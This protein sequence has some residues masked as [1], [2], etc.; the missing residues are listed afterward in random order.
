VADRPIDLLV[1]SLASGQ[2]N[3]DEFIDA[4]EHQVQI[5]A[6]FNEG[7]AVKGSLS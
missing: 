7:V 2:L 5:P 4:I 1:G 3:L 6:P